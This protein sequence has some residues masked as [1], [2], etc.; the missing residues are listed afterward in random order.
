MEPLGYGCVNM[1][2]SDQANFLSGMRSVFQGTCGSI[3]AR[4]FEL[5]WFVQETASYCTLLCIVASATTR[6]PFSECTYE[7]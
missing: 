3:E 7:A 2:Q 4:G 1:P 5:Q 6:H